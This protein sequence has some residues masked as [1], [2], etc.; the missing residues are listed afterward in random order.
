MVESCAPISL[1]EIEIGLSSIN[2]FCIFKKKSGYYKGMIRKYS[3]LLCLNLKSII[4]N[5]K[6]YVQPRYI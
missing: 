3:F 4:N 6:Y 1:K 2:I 5:Y